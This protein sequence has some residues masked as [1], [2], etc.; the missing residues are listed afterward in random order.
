MK[1]QTTTSEARAQSKL[2]PFLFRFAHQ[3]PEVPSFVVRYDSA[4]Q[5][6]QV[7]SDGLWIDSVD[8][9]R[10]RWPETTFTRVRSET[11]DDE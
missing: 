4:R 7:L 2:T 5:L 1:P 8:A 10:E 11:S 9:Q 3:L 6:S